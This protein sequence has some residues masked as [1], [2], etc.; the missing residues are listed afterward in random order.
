MDFKALLDLLDKQ[1]EK[2]AKK[3]NAKLLELLENNGD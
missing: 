1:I 2:S 3:L